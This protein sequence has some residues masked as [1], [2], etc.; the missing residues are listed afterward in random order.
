[1]AV[2]NLSLL[3]RDEITVR[4]VLKEV[5][6]F[7]SSYYG[8]YETMIT[9]VF[10]KSSGHRYDEYDLDNV[11]DEILDSPIVSYRAKMTKSFLDMDDDR[12]IAIYLEI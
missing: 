3:A 10:D 11:S 8:V 2:L 12:F 7:N 1:M 4:D 9:E 6:Q 5:K